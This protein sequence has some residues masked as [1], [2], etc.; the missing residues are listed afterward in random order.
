MDIFGLLVD[1][2]TNTDR[3]LVSLATDYGTLISARL[4]YLP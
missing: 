3:F 1:L 4:I 2:F